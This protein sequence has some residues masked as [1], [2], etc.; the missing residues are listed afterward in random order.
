MTVNDIDNTNYQIK[1]HN[2]RDNGCMYFIIDNQTTV[3]CGSLLLISIL[4][5]EIILIYKFTRLV[6][7]YLQLY[8]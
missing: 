7:Y 1:V 4:D 3:Y 2:Y 8:F 5:N 6:Y